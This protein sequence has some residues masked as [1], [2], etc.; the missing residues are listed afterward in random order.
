MQAPNSK[1]LRNVVHLQH[2]NSEG[3]PILRIKTGGKL[4]AFSRFY[5]FLTKGW[6]P[7]CS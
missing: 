6:S 4:K 1:Q 3:Q 7:T 5:I 2:Q